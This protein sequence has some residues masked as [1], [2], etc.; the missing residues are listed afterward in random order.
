MKTTEC[1]SVILCD[2]S[3][4]GWEILSLDTSFSV[5][6]GAPSV[7]GRLLDSL[8]YP[9]P[10]IDA[11]S[12][13]RQTVHWFRHAPSLPPVTLTATALPGGT[14]VSHFERSAVGA[15]GGELSRHLISCHFIRHFASSQPLQA[16]R[17]NPIVRPV[18]IYAFTPD[19]VRHGSSAL[20]ETSHDLHCQNG[21]QQRSFAH[22]AREEDLPGLCVQSEPFEPLQCSQPCSRRVPPPPSHNASLGS[23]SRDVNE[24][25]SIA[26]ERRGDGGA[27]C[28]PYREACA[29]APIEPRRA[30][31]SISPQSC[32]TAFL[33]NTLSHE[34]RTPLNGIVALTELLLSTSLTPEQR[35]LLNTVLESGQSL[36]RILSAPSIPLYHAC[37]VVVAVAAPTAKRGLE[38]W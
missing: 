21:Y 32:N 31:A 8:L 17:L 6:S 3:V 30:S 36:T 25:L 13:I 12:K 14:Y 26:V 9:A 22:A 28:H 29:S 16:L 24:I 2:A 5:L 19:L 18:S 35:D 11:A 23:Y 10:T 34:L 15:N 33:A 20:C 1:S 38:Q 7:P 4:T 37:I 27:H